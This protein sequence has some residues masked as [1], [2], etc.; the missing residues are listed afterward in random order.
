MATKLSLYKGAL[1]ALGETTI[2]ELT[3]TRPARYTLDEIWDNGFRDLVLSAGFWNFATRTIEI[4]YDSDI[5]PG[6][7]GGYTRA[8]SKPSDW[9]RTVMVSADGSFNTPFND[10]IDEQG[11]WFSDLDTMFIKHISNHADYGYNLAIWPMN[12]TRYAEHVMAAEGAERITQNRVKKSDVMDIAGNWLSI[13]KSTDAM[14]QPI[15]LP[16]SGSWVKARG[17][18]GGMTRRSG[19]WES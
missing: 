14:N 4:D 11:Y 1:R 10:Y 6:I 15:S 8:F 3:D 12:F 13:A 2:S 19:G 17:G 5:T 18:S 7:T 16:P 9:L